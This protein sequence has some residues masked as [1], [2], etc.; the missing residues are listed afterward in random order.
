MLPRLR[1]AALVVGFAAA[2]LGPVL[3]TSPGA[4]LS[5]PTVTL[6]VAGG[7]FATGDTVVVTVVISNP[8][9]DD[10]RVRL[11]VRI[12]GTY[13]PAPPVGGWATGS[14]DPGF[15]GTCDPA[16]R[17]GASFDQT[18]TCDGGVAGGGSATVTVTAPARLSAC[19]PDAFPV[20]LT[21]DWGDPAL[22][23]TLIDGGRDVAVVDLR[24][25]ETCAFRVE[26]AAAAPT[27]G[28]DGWVTWVMRLVN[29]GD[30][31]WL[32]ND[33][34]PMGVFLDSFDR[35]TFDR[36]ELVAAPAGWTCDP[37]GAPYDGG[38][39]PPYDVLPPGLVVQC[40]A[41][42][43]V[44]FLLDR[45]EAVEFRY[46]AHVPSASG[47]CLPEVEA[48]N[49]AFAATGDLWGTPE[50]PTPLEPDVRSWA[51]PPAVVRV[52]GTDDDPACRPEGDPPA[53]PAAPD[54][55]PAAG[56]ATPV[57]T[58]A[59]TSVLARTGLPGGVRGSVALGVTLFGTGG[60]LLA[61]SR[62]RLGGA[63]SGRRA[64]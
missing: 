43:D 36:V 8:D 52:L 3:P 56:E 25:A 53:G 49:R 59:G 33:A 17:V 37:E 24:P 55:A 40:G 62:R 14:P 58:G 57:S 42:L 35:A 15:D 10:V 5:A 31:Y 4:A 6:G 54:G 21:W 26:K 51:S 32:R 34:R 47:E 16:T 23:D 13:A 63:T 29:D 46:R 18:V 44:E 27:V 30:P 12:E 20:R 50:G 22:P 28:R 1:S 45:G 61:G 38:A 39:P 60:A 19:A 7:P 41:Q 48:T 64:A 9:P 2:A 11:R